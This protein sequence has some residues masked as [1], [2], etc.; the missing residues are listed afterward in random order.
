MEAIIKK[1]VNFPPKWKVP[2]GFTDARDL[3]VGYLL[4]DAWIGNGDRHHENWGFVRP[5]TSQTGIYLAPTK[6]SENI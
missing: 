6:A 1:S 2:D 4:L 5:K 3:F